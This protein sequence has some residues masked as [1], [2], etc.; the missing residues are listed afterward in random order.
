MPLNLTY[1]DVAFPAIA[2]LGLGVGA[3]LA[4]WGYDIA[5]KSGTRAPIKLPPVESSAVEVPVDVTEEEAEE[6]KKQGI[7]VKTAADNILD[8]AVQGSIG[9]LSAV[10]GWSALDSF[11]DKKRKDKAHKSLERS[12]RR[13]QA[14]INGEADPADAGLSRAMK[15]AEDVY[16]DNVGTSELGSNT[17]EFQKVSGIVADLGLRGAEGI[18]E[19]LAPVGIPLGI[20]GT[21]V[22]MNAYNKSKDENKYRAKAK[23]MRDYLNNIGAST[24][25]AVMVPIL[26]KRD[27]ATENAG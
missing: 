27:P 3:R 4:R 9:T 23:A 2:G 11:L 12:R 14:L 7:K 21:I 20:A 8:T 10:G 1:G 5:N 16:I 17:A 22:A 15:V 19:F 25:T 6:L 24:P 13:V 26:K 18:G